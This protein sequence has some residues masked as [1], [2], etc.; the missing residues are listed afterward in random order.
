MEYKKKNYYFLEEKK[1]KIMFTY[2]HEIETH[3]FVQ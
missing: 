3:I 1:V 2:L